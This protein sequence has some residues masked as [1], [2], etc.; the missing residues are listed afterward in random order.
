LKKE[1]II[2]PVSKMLKAGTIGNMARVVETNYA[3][4][5]SADVD[6]ELSNMLSQVDIASLLQSYSIELEQVERVFPTTAGQTYFLA[7]NRLN[8]SLFYSKFFYTTR[9]PLTLEQLSHAWA[10]LSQQMSLLRTVF[11]STGQRQL[12]FIQAVLQHV[13]NPVGWHES[14]AGKDSWESSKREIGLIPVSLHASCS[15]NG[16]MV[17]L[18]IHH[19]LYD[20]VSLPRLMD[21]LAKLCTHREVDIISKPA[22][23]DFVAFQ[24][25]QSPSATRRAFWERYIGQVEYT[26]IPHSQETSW[27]RIQ[28]YRPRLF[29]NMSA[30]ETIAKSQGLSVQALI[31]AIYARVHLKLLCK[32]TAGSTYNSGR[33]VVGF[34]LANRGHALAGLPDLVAPILNIVPLIIDNA[35]DDKSIFKIS[36]EIQA[37]LRRISMVEHSG[38]SLIEIADWTGLHLD[39]CINLLRLPEFDNSTENAVEQH[40]KFLPMDLEV[41][42]GNDST[43]H[44]NNINHELSQQDSWHPAEGEDV[45]KLLLGDV[46]KV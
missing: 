33:L 13:E 30:I 7:M 5:Q 4:I 11:I 3:G 43:V 19:A 10:C 22:L 44:L 1:S 23:S 2:L 45:F 12:P 25:I 27:E 8:P 34:Y 21:A 24:N 35:T 18:Q 38:V 29:N 20:A 16:T 14:V 41:V 40:V 42:Y 26:Q 9:T 17:M 6:T 37:D 46:F 36:Q 15:S 28:Y 31:L 32:T 39:V